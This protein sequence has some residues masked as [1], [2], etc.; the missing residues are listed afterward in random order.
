MRTASSSGR[1]APLL[2]NMPAALGA[3]KPSH[4]T[5][6][7]YG[8]YGASCAVRNAGS[9]LPPPESRSLFVLVAV[10]SALLLTMECK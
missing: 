9:S 10:Y 7:T 5:H 3:A 1:T 4:E 6:Q 8:T 2:A